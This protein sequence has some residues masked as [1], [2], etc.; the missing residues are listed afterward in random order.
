M[1]AEGT[2]AHSDH[3]RD[4]AHTLALSSPDGN[5]K[6]RDDKKLINYR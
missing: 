6:I 4:I 2:A 1:V 5:Y 3:A